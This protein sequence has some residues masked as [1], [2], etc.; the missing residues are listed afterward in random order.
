MAVA[1]VALVAALG[2]SAVA[3]PGK[4]RIDK[5]DIKRGAVNGADIRNGSVKGADVAESSLATVPNAVS[6]QRADNAQNAV[7]A[8][9]ASSAVS[10]ATAANATNADNA[11]AVGGNVIQSF[12][13]E[14]APGAAFPGI[15]IGGVA[16][17]GDC[18]GG[19]FNLDARNTG[20]Q[21]AAFLFS[22]VADGTPYE[23]SD[24]DFTAGDNDAIV[25]DDAN[26]GTGTATA[27]FADG[28]STTLVFAFINGGAVTTGCQW[29]GHV[30]SG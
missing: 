21:A 14:A 7:S 18:N 8:G 27:M 1:F 13:D 20:G 26:T 12:S 6:A 10:A 5:N 23:E 28:S 19:N 25:P 9:T 4:N 30:I 16:V 15:D 24:T 3:L 17:D 2:G 22:G 29:S 11:N